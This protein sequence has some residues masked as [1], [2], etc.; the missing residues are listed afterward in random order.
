MYGGLEASGPGGL[1][2]WVIFHVFFFLY[3]SPSLFYTSPPAFSIPPP[4]PF[5][6]LSILVARPC[7]HRPRPNFAGELLE[8][9]WVLLGPRWPRVLPHTPPK[10]KDSWFWTPT[11]WILDVNLV[12]L[13]SNFEDFGS[14]LAWCCY[15]VRASRRVALCRRHLDKDFL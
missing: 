1:E 9:V 3:L 12:I 11:W 14:Q 4:Q 5:L 10:T 2:A 15:C 6:Y 8:G 13:C 7:I